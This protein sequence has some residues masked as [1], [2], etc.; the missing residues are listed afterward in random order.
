MHYFLQEI[1]CIFFHN[2]WTYIKIVMNFRSKNTHPSETA[3]S[4]SFRN[5]LECGAHLDCFPRVS[6]FSPQIPLHDSH[7][8]K[9][10]INFFLK[11]PSKKGKKNHA[12]EDKRAIGRRYAH[13]GVGTPKSSC[14]SREFSYKYKPRP[15]HFTHTHFIRLCSGRFST[16]S[17]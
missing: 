4:G 10:E 13:L 9:A 2:F 7:T 16:L 3:R 1:L 6:R 8:N 12:K 15:S 14:L 11:S 5:I 17:L